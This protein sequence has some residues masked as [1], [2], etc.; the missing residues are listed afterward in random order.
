MLKLRKTQW[1]LSATIHQLIAENIF[2]RFCYTSI[3]VIPNRQYG[4]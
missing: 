2:N 3:K 4:I 1:Q